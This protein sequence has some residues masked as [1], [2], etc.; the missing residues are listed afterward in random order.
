MEILKF[1]ELE[2]RLI[3]YQ[4]EYV[5]VDRDVAQLYGVET[6]D[7]NKAVLNNPDKFPKGYLREL[8]D[9]EKN[10]LVEKF[11]RFNTLKHSTVNPKVFT[12][13]GLYMLATII[14]SKVATHTTLKIIETF[15]KIKELSR[16]INS[17]MKTKDIELQKELAAKSNRILEEIIEIEE[18]VLTDHEDGEVVETTTKFEFNL[19]FAKVSKSIKKIKR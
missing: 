19:G 3:Q 12:E 7:I 18:D 13:K 5:L 11:H 10:E 1:E 17:I 2:N 9:E 6:R 4:N 8:N 16:N 15:A 14:K